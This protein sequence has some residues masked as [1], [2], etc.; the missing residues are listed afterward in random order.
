MAEAKEVD[1]DHINISAVFCCH[2]TACQQTRAVPQWEHGLS[3]ESSGHFSLTTGQVALYGVSGP[4]QG[5]VMQGTEHLLPGKLCRAC[6][7]KKELSWPSIKSLSL[8][9][10]T[11]LIGVIDLAEIY[12]NPCCS[13]NYTH[14]PVLFKT[15][16]DQ[17][18]PEVTHVPGTR[19]HRGLLASITRREMISVGDFVWSFLYV[20]WIILYILI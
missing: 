5:R 20:T 18:K 10:F 1:S 7:G 6:A 2:D 16:N 11:A 3:C 9:E 4:P 14:S 17:L 13:Q 12:P 15:Q 8:L 19:S